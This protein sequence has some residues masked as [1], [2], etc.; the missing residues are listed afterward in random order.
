MSQKS[1]KAFR[2]PGS[3]KII[4]L[5]KNFG[6]TEK[7][8]FGFLSAVF[9][10]SSISLLWNLNQYFMI[11]IPADG[12]TISEGVIG[13]PRFVNPVLAISDT[14]KDL[15]SL[16]YSGLMRYENNELVPDLA[17]KYEV[18]SDGLVYTFTLKDNIYFHD[19][20][21][22]TTDD[23]EFTIKKAQ[24]ALLKSP[25]RASWADIAIEKVDNK[26]IKFTLKNP[27]APFIE[28]T[29]LGILPKHIWKNVDTEQFIFSQ[30]NIEPIGSGPY[31][32]KTI[33]RDSGGLLQSYE[34]IPFKK[35][36]NGKPHI[37]KMIINFYP[38]EKTL[39]E[40]WGEGLIENMG[41]IST[42]EALN[43]EKL[44]QDQNINHVPLPRIFGVFLNQNHAPVLV[45][46][47]V[48]HALDLA[49]DRGR[50]IKEVLG[51]Y[52]TIVD[53]ALPANLIDE[54]SNFQ[55]SSSTYD[56][57]KKILDKDG[58]IM[59]S[60]GLLEKKATKKDTPSQTLQFT[61]AT[62][63][64]ED[65]K[66]TAEIVRQEWEKIGVKVTVKI[67]EPGDLS[68]LIQSRKYDAVLFGEMIGR[69][70]DLYPFWHSSQK[71]SPGFNISMYVNTKADKILEDI[72][73]NILSAKDKKAK[74]DQLNDIIGED[75]P[76]IFLYSPD[77]I[78]IT[79]SKLQ[80]LNLKEIS[81]PQD[82]FNDIMDWFINT[83]KIWKIFKKNT[84]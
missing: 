52:G 59:N 28:S 19:G 72:R 12:G 64:I 38:S 54:D 56:V 76:A 46:K 70:M 48:R 49:V 33:N 75:T 51:G 44:G 27:Y 39:I 21:P 50:I 22:I 24:D 6:P 65:L 81:T 13:M 80:G 58:W 17:K 1:K 67:F 29:T 43:I 4:N 7:T 26:I 35:W 20:T 71:N 23:I 68:Q 60:N 63:N 66:E 57:A 11:P 15:T 3:E 31:V 47:E 37:S 78:Y 9:V 30:F 77:Y 84:I 25:R 45:D 83:D 32:L 41:G 8:I 53:T 34:L 18:S 40:A 36:N 42:K 5:I 73:T 62:T 10:I 74:Y 82:R 16:I 79:S 55:F 69:D 14:D 2:I 61:L